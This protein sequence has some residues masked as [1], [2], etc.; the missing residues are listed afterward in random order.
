M[1]YLNIL[2]QKG[3]KNLI[4]YLLGKRLQSKKDL[5]QKEHNAFEYVNDFDDSNKDGKEEELYVVY[6]DNFN[7]LKNIP[8]REKIIYFQ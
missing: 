1:T 4:L 5:L 2:H 7:I 3:D 8:S 6:Y